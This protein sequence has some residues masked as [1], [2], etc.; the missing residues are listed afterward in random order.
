MRRLLALA[1][2]CGVVLT[3]MASAQNLIEETEGI[4]R[5]LASAVEAAGYE[6]VAVI[7]PLDANDNPSA[8]G[9]FIAEELSGAMVNAG[10]LRVIDRLSLQRILDEQRLSVSGLVND[11]DA[12]QRIGDLAGVEVLI[13]GTY[14][15]LGSNV[16]LSLKGLNVQS[17]QSVAAVNTTLR[18]DESVTSLLGSNRGISAL[19]PSNADWANEMQGANHSSGVEYDVD[20]GIYY[21]YNLCDADQWVEFASERSYSNVSFVLTPNAP[22]SAQILLSVGGRL[23]HESLHAAQYGDAGRSDPTNVSVSVGPNS[24]DRAI[25]IILKKYQEYSFMNPRCL[26]V[27]SLSAIEIR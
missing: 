23:V 2:T 18:I 20:S 9:R 7:D 10:Q 1:I 17:A 26:G 14:F 13:V 4:A 21:I 6:S 22:M 15:V 11:A 16:R 19:E 25:R 8:F 5:R 24:P 27:F 12:V 3:Q